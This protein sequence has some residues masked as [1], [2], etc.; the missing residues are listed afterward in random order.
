M[1]EQNLYGT[2]N[3]YEAAYCLA[4]GFKLNGKQRDGAKVIIYFEGPNV[5]RKAIEFYN[6]GKVEAKAF[7]DSYRTLKDYVF[8]G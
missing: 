1:A 6:G 4:K 7:A 3:L 5:H 8:E 2:K